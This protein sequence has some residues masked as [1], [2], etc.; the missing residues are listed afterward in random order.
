MSGINSKKKESGKIPNSLF[1]NEKNKSEKI[2]FVRI[3][4]FESPLKFYY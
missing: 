2:I 4:H 1:K 3:L